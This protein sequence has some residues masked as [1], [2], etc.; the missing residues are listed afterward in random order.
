MPNGGK[1]E[2]SLLGVVKWTPLEG[3]IT[4]IN[5]FGLG[6]FFRSLEVFILLVFVLLL[7]FSLCSL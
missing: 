1:R 5:L 6:Q 3:L 4:S 7:G 2:R